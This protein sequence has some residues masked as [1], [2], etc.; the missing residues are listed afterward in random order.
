MIQLKVNEREF[1][2][3]LAALR[4]YK[5]QGQSDPTSRSE[6]IDAI[7]TN[8]RTVIALDDQGVDQLCERLNLEG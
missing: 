4:F 8:L 6:A 3:I 7:A 1:H 5:V 2:T